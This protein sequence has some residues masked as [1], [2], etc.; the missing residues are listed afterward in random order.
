MR[1]RPGCAAGSS[2][3][4]AAARW[5][6][7]LVFGMLG[8]CTYP[9]AGMVNPATGE[10][11]TCTSHLPPGFSS[12]Q[13]NHCLDNLRLSGFVKAEELKAEQRAAL[14]PKARQLADARGARASGGGEAGAADASADPSGRTPGS[15]RH[16]TMAPDAETIVLDGGETVRYLGIRRLEGFQAPTAAARFGE[17][18]AFVRQLVEG[19]T[20]RLEYDAQ[21]RDPGG[22]VWAYVYLLD[23]RMV[24]AQLVERGYAQ[25]D[26]DQSNVRYAP[27]FQRLEAGARAAGRGF[28]AAR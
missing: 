13:M 17:A 26:P 19:Q 20:V 24:N 21:T 11:Q 22:R 14:E 10:V 27:L 3:R 2:A 15:W 28:W 18:V 16:V 12:L 6:F 8:A 5:G 9:I 4:E 23:G 7:L 25:A 1:T